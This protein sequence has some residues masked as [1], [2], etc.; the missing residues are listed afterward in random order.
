L[1]YQVQPFVKDKE[2]STPEDTDSDLDVTGGPG[3]ADM[4][5]EGSGRRVRELLGGQTWPPSLSLGRYWD[6]NTAP[7]VSSRSVL[8]AMSLLE[9]THTHALWGSLRQI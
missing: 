6:T 1:H 2:N 9:H 3:D 8:Y 7:A 5:H 4:Q